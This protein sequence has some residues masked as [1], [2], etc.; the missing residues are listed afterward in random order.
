MPFSISPDAKLLWLGEKHSEAMATLRYGIYEN[1]GFLVLTGNIGTGKTALINRLIRE[2][3][4]PVLA[5]TIPDPELNSI[6]FFNFLANEFKLNGNF[7]SKGDFLI[8]FKN[9]LHQAYA[10]DQ[11]VLLIIDEA[12][13]L[14]PDL[15]EQVRLLSNIEIHNRKL[16][17]I[18]FVGQS[19]FNK[20]L[21]MEQNKATQQRIAIRYHLEPLAEKEIVKYIR[22]RLKICGVTNEIF[23]PKAIRKIYY[24]SRG[25][26][27][28]INILCDHCLLTGYSIGLKSIGISIVKECAKELQMI[29]D[30]EV[31]HNKKKEFLKKEKKQNPNKTS[32]PRFQSIEFAIIALI[33]FLWGI[34]GYSFYYLKNENSII[35]GYKLIPAPK[36]D[37]SVLEQDDFFTQGNPANESANK[38]KNTDQKYNSWNEVKE[39][40]ENSKILIYFN[41]NSNAL[42]SESLHILDSFSKF[43]LQYPDSNII[44]KGYTDS[45]GNHW[46]NKKL[47][48]TRAEA[49]KSYLTGKGISPLKIETFGMGSE[50][51]IASNETPAERIKN[52]RVEIRISEIH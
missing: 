39:Y 47:S 25:N 4:I 15:L 6:D 14:N 33:A 52:R 32:R 1:K 30:R 31:H 42:N 34:A 19:E 16:I 22:F 40:T 11:K 27:R 50:N 28:L 45:K 37:Y 35:S 3:D 26:P 7:H 24:F 8:S 10:S 23:Q 44:I 18:F 43:I 20:M 36:S 46:Y 2:I 41:N 12:Q 49:V 13:R 21:M 29:L 48:Q 5:A 9:F 38:T 51:P 17:N